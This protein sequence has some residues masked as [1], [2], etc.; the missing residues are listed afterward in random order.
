M[1]E[2]IESVF[3]FTSALFLLYVSYRS[4]RIHGI[5]RSLFVFPFLSWISILVLFNK[6]TFAEFLASFDPDDLRSFLLIFYATLVPIYIYY[7]ITK[8]HISTHYFVLIYSA[9]ISS[10]YFI[11]WPIVIPFHFAILFGLVYAHRWGRRYAHNHDRLPS[12]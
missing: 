9:M 7:K 12:P 5:L 8:R 3:I 1:S 6:L 2:I 4:I 10:F 11:F